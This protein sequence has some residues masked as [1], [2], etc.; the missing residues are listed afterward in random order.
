MLL[1]R[2]RTLP[3]SEQRGLVAQILFRQTL[4]GLQEAGRLERV[5]GQRALAEDTLPCA[6]EA[7]ACRNHRYP[8]L[9]GEALVDSGAG[10][11]SAAS[12]TS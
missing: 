7:E 12:L 11:T 6:L 8:D 2:L 10:I 5:V 1:A 9:T 3:R 4:L